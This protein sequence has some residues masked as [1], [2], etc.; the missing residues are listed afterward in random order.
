MQAA[1]L[2][3][4]LLGEEIGLLQLRAAFSDGDDVGIAAIERHEL[5]EPPDAGEIE[6][7]L[8][9]GAFGGPAGLEKTKTFRDR[10][11]RPV[12]QNIEQRAALGAGDFYLTN[13]VRR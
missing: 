10:Q 2:H 9:A 12:V 5:A 8:Q 6:P 1:L 7:A 3:A 11:A 13:V 4:E